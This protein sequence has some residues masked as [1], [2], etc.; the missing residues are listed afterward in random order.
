MTLSK[1]TI[2]IS[3]HSGFSLI[4]MAVVLMILGTLM[5]GVLVAISQ[6]MESSRRSS[7]LAQLRQV[8]D[9][10]YG[11]AQTNERLPCPATH[12]SG[13]RQSPDTVAGNCT[14]LH[15]FVPAGTL[16]LFGPTNDDGL[17]LDPWQNPIRYSI[18]PLD[19]DSDGNYDFANA[20]DLASLFA[21]PALITAGVANML[22]ICDIN[23]CSGMTISDMV[24]ALV[25]TLGPDWATFSSADEIENAETTLGTYAIANDSQFVVAGYTE[26]IFDDQLIWLSPYV[27]FNRM[28]SAGKLP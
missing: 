18:A 2:L 11:Y 12:T 16:S 20:L 26:D 5:S 28:I 4:E 22:R 23:A 13:G 25:Y 1:R 27:L 21:T 9:A 24:P 19:S 15:G 6:T 3:Q 14:T 17:L 8:E 10:L 7:A